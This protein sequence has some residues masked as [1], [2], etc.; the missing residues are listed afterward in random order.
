M[1]GNACQHLEPW[2]G[3]AQSSQ[4]LQRFRS[5]LLGRNWTYF[6][7]NHSTEK[8]I[9]QLLSQHLD[10]FAKNNHIFVSPNSQQVTLSGDSP[11]PRKPSGTQK[12]KE[13]TTGMKSSPR[14]IFLQVL[15]FPDLLVQVLQFLS[16]QPWRAIYFTSILKS[17][18]YVYLHLT[19]HTNSW[20]NQQ[21]KKS[22]DYDFQMTSNSGNIS[23]TS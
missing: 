9:L 8:L 5:L 23:Q 6:E 11:P 14:G 1:M 22:V 19:A 20:K 13:K 16:Q 12:D 7:S 3:V 4:M 15:G 18:P 17:Q 21:T 10:C 2:I